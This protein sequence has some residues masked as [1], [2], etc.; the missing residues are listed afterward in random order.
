M[1]KKEIEPKIEGT[2]PKRKFTL[3]FNT[4]IWIALFGFLAYRI[5]ASMS[6]TVL[7]IPYSTFKTALNEGKVNSVNINKITI[8]GKMN[9]GRFYDH[10]HR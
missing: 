10:P 2:P 8:T 6:P 4:L 5:F 1:F 9:D 7:D 3:T